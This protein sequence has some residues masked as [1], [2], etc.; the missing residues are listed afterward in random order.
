MHNPDPFILLSDAKYALIHHHDRAA[1][2]ALGQKAL[3]IFE[4]DGSI[5]STSC[6]NAVLKCGIVDLLSDLSIRAGGKLSWDNFESA[7]QHSMASSALMV[8][9]LLFLDEMRRQDVYYGQIYPPLLD[10]ARRNQ[11]IHLLEWLV[12]NAFTAIDP[13]CVMP[14]LIDTALYH[15]SSMAP[16]LAILLRQRLPGIQSILHIMFATCNRASLEKL[17][18]ICIS[19]DLDPD[20]TL[21]LAQRS[22]MPEKV[23]EILVLGNS[24]HG[25]LEARRREPDLAALLSR[26]VDGK[27]MDSISLPLTVR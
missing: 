24:W 11:D 23:Y 22:D 17:A 15:T 27:F 2:I 16:E 10:L 26:P 20:I 6:R 19:C 5:R 7:W 14:I 13:I 3:D 4:R 18:S 8:D 1:G 21:S 9:G 25:R 12:N